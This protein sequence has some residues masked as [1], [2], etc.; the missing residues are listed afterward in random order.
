MKRMLGALA[1]TLGLAALTFAG[2]PAAIAA[3]PPS[4]DAIYVIPCDNDNT[5]G[6]LFRVDPGTGNATRV[7]NW[8]NPDVDVYSC[9]GPGAFDP[10]TGYG[11]W[12]AWGTGEGGPAGYLIRIDLST[13]NN[14]LVG[15]FTVAGNNYY[16]PIALAIDG[17]GNAWASSYGS[18]T[19]ADTFFSLNLA[20]AELTVI[21]ATG[22]PASN[23][24]GLGW[25]PVTNAIY[26]YNRTNAT[27]YT[28]NTTT[29]A[30]TSFASPALNE[31]FLMYA[32]HFDSAGNVWAIN[33]DL[34]SAPLADL[35]DYDYLTVNNPRPDEP[36][37]I[38]SESI[39]I[40]PAPALPA[41][42]A[43]GGVS[44]AL[45]GAGVLLLVAG[46]VLLVRRRSIA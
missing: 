33:G 24:F 28:V 40:A 31:E 8:S 44:A 39:I 2:A 20:T 25:D 9:A 45:A 13:G 14:T 4:G 37:L 26:A 43:E 19:P 3:T 7:G 34:V 10:V 12:I 21:G 32:M 5:Y 38:Y 17:A 18:A 30:F 27:M 6:Q 36:G 46:G 41:T 29:G 15:Q 35:A 42:G 23:T 11:Y 16:T 22:A 1:A